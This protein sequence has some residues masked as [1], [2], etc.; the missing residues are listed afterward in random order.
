MTLSYVRR[1]PGGMRGLGQFSPCIDDP[2]LD[3]SDPGTLGV[4]TGPGNVTGSPSGISAALAQI[5]TPIAKSA[6]VIG[7]QYMSYQNPLYQKQTVALTPQ[8][9]VVYA[10]NQPTSTAGIF[11]GAGAAGVGSLLPILLVG[12]VIAIVVSR[13]K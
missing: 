10:T 3:C 9:Q 8:G 7:Q 2:T 4:S 11:G 12:V 13:G 1:Y 6:G 5:F